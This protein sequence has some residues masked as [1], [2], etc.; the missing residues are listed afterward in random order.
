MKLTLKNISH[1]GDFFAIPFFLLTFFYF[2]NKPERNLFEDILM[3]FALSGALA[4]I[5]FSYIYLFY[6]NKKV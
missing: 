3:L 4:D 1:I 6:S 2:Y 5:L